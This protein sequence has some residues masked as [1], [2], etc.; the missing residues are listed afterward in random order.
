MLDVIAST[1]VNLFTGTMP[2]YVLLG[3]AVGLIVGILPALG[4]TAGMALR[5]RVRSARPTSRR[6]SAASSARWC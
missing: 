2:L 6:W 1:F 3:V 5:P 4:T